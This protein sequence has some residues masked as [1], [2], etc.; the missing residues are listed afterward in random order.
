[1][2]EK[3]VRWRDEA[4]ISA[5]SMKSTTSDELAALSP[6]TKAI[7]D[8]QIAIEKTRMKSEYDTK[9]KAGRERFEPGRSRICDTTLSTTLG[10]G[11]FGGVSHGVSGWRSPRTVC[12]GCGC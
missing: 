9:Q 7:I 2:K 12:R 4:S 3:A 11:L 1:M 6:K 10:A 5:N 8:K